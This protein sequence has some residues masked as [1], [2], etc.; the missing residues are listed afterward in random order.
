MRLT[1][2]AQFGSPFILAA[3][4]GPSVMEYGCEG[5]HLDNLFS[6]ATK[7]RTPPENDHQD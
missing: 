4:V 3:G 7:S 6:G 2:A 1:L 5:N